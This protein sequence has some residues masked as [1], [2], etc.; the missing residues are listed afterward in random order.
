ME[1]DGTKEEAYD[2]DE[3]EKKTP[4]GR[5]DC[6]MQFTKSQPRSRIDAFFS[7]SLSLSSHWSSDK[8]TRGAFRW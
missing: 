8:A 1:G 4:A 6:F 5:S 3:E 7:L 2:D